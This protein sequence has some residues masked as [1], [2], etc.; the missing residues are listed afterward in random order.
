[1]TS[2]TVDNDSSTNVDHMARIDATMRTATSNR[3]VRFVLAP[4]LILWVGGAGCLIG[5]EG[6]VAVAATVADPHQARH[7][8]R[9]PTM[10]P[11][12]ATCSSSGSQSCCA[13]GAV[14]PKRPVKR[15]SE[16]YSA[17]DAIS[18]SSSGMMRDCPLAVE[19]AITPK[20]RDG[21]VVFAP[22]FAH[23]ILRPDYLLER[24]SPLSKPLRLPNRGHTYLRCCVFL[25]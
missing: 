17:L 14:E 4:M 13:R 18:G 9:K 24:T 25:I 12:G 15:S 11:S 6:M 2:Q 5:C 8:G 10:V 20:E 19:K 23:S 16:S 22:V 1:M 3:I 7:S 21:Q